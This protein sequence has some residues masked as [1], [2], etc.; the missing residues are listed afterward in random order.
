[1]SFESDIEWLDEW[2]KIESCMKMYGYHFSDI[3]FNGHC[4]WCG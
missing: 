1:M 3:E 2:N 4:E